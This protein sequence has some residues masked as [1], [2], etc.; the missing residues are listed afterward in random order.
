MVRQGDKKA[1]AAS[2]DSP[3]G[4]ALPE[5]SRVAIQALVSQPAAVRIAGLPELRKQMELGR[6]KAIEG[7]NFVAKAKIRSQLETAGAQVAD[8]TVGKIS[9]AFAQAL[10]PIWWFNV[11][12]LSL[13]V[14]STALIPSIPLRGKAQPA[15]PSE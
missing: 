8:Q 7:T 4:L 1:L 10:G 12:L 2:F 14:V 9:S 11:V 3:E 15:P 13:L 5:A 6:D